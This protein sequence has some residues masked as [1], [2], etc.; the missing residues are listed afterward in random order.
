M[1]QVS[2]NVRT[3]FDNYEKGTNSSDPKLVASQYGDAFMFGGPQGVQAVKMEDFLKALLKRDGF[4]KAV[5]LTASRIKSLEETRLDENYVMV[6]VCW[7]M[8]FEK[9]S[10]QPV[11]VDLVTTYILYSQE[12]LLQI[13]VQLDH[14]DFMKKVGDFGLL[15]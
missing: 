10:D 5:G 12:S 1:K 2:D 8:R 7:N 15:P 3:F 11:D 13:V 6:K 14:Q 4:F 9:H